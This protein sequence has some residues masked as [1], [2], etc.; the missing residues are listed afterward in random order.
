MSK[1]LDPDHSVG[2]GLGPNYLQWLLAD[3]KVV[4]SKENFCRLLITYTDSLEPD[5]ACRERSGSVV[6]CLT[7]DGRTRV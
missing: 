1:G 3:D 4:L 2:P 6:E 7:Q 5:Q